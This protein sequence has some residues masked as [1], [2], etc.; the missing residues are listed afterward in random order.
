[1]DGYTTL[2]CSGTLYVAQ[3]SSVDDQREN[4]AHWVGS[5]DVGR[6]QVVCSADVLLPFIAN[7]APLELL[8]DTSISILPSSASWSLPSSQPSSAP[9]LSTSR[10]WLCDLLRCDDIPGVQSAVDQLTN[11][12][13]EWATGWQAHT[14]P[15]GV[16][17]TALSSSFCSASSRRPRSAATFAVL[18][19]RQPLHPKQYRSAT[20]SQLSAAAA[21]ASLSSHSFTSSCS[22][23]PTLVPTDFPS[24][25]PLTFVSSRSLRRGCDV[26][27]IASP[28]GLLSPAVFHNSVSGGIVS[29]VVYAASS[30]MST[31]VVAALTE[32]DT[33]VNGG[34]MRQTVVQNSFPSTDVSFP[35][36]LHFPI[37]GHPTSASSYP[38]PASSPSAG[39]HRSIAPVFLT[40]CRCLPGSEGG[41]VVLS[42]SSSVL[43]AGLVT[44]PLHL[45]NTLS[46]VLLNN[47]VSA[48]AV[49]H[50][51][52]QDERT[53]PH[54]CLH[55]L[56]SPTAVAVVNPLTSSTTVPSLSIPSPPS[57]P[58]LAS[59][60]VSSSS[61]SAYPVS[62]S[63]ATVTGMVERAERSLAIA[64]VESSWASAIVLTADGYIATNA[65]LLA[66]FHAVPSALN[67]KN[68]SAPASA[69]SLSASV[70][71]CLPSS[72]HHPRQS[73]HWH[74]ATVVYICRSPWD[75]ALLKIDPPSPLTPVSL[76]LPSSDTAQPGD[77]V[78]VL[79]H[80]LFSPSSML[81]PTLTRGVLSQCVS[82]P[83]STTSTL[84]PDFAASHSPVL[85]QT[86]SAVHNG[87]SGGLLLS[88]AG[89]CLGMV[90]S[91]IQHTALPAA[92]DS[93][94]TPPSSATLSSNSSVIIPQL[95]L[96]IPAAVLLRLRSRLQQQQAANVRFDG[97]GSSESESGEAETV[98]S[99][100]AGMW[101]EWE[102]GE[103]VWRAEVERMWGLSVVDVW[104]ADVKPRSS[105]YAEVVEMVQRMEREKRSQRSAKLL[106]SNVTGCIDHR[107][108]L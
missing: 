44:L 83:L 63:R 42:S 53:I 80:A 3:H 91:N 105:K 48:E 1:M 21:A 50:W 2:Q 11:L 58:G 52:H 34:M 108:R 82:L 87:N 5:A 46:P 103:S 95:N 68:S 24:F 39:E 56:A 41:P 9:P 35:R 28:Y 30:A 26:H 36:H 20:T 60:A 47:V 14:Q 104:E 16:S 98:A 85:L 67:S 38:A 96:S 65:H 12:S 4:H 19:A 59:K 40:D 89:T 99:S 43:L 73:R 18:R 17:I 23:S 55:S 93:P 32:R 97:D 75:L 57:I 101:R 69:P 77:R 84:S 54:P 72:L 8:D 37:Q 106:E 31:E 7:S 6:V 90:T 76:P 61:L 15:G 62:A 71:V 33:S 94:I 70:S 102:A 66:P 86:D 92:P 51:L 74:E 100:G 64:K 78:Y 88:R 13:D 25:P 29:N 107:A 22:S 27:V 79:G 81:L 49:W 45:T 10:W